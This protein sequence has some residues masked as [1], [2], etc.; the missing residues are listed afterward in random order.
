MRRMERML[1][2]LQLQLQLTLQLQ[3]QRRI[4]DSQIELL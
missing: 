3:L 1:G 2:Q 4:A